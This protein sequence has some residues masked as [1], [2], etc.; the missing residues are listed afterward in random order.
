[1]KKCPYCAE[2][3]KSDAIKC[4]FCGEWL[5]DRSAKQSEAPTK[6]KEKSVPA[7]ESVERPLDENKVNELR[8]QYENMPIGQLLTLKRHYSL[9]DYTPACRKAL[10]EAFLK[11]N[12]E[13][14][15]EENSPRNE[16]YEAEEDVVKIVEYPQYDKVGGWLLLFCL[17]LI[18]FTPLDT[19]FTI[20]KSWGIAARLFETYPTFRGMFIFDTILGIGLAAFSIYAGMLLLIINL[21]AAKVAKIFLLVEWSVTII[22]PFLFFSVGFSREIREAFFGNMRLFFF[23]NLFYVGIWYVYLIKSKRVK[24]TYIRHHLKV[25]SQRR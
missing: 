3:I 5:N 14:G 16:K 23:R 17:S 2:A 19:I 12:G 9:K 4:R 20:S 22:E 18:L 21:K 15:I 1:M 8:L 11:R 24:G 25:L 10:E 7:K 13:L 6:E